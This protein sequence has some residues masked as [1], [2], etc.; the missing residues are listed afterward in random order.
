MMPQYGGI[1]RRRYFRLAYPVADRPVCQIRDRQ[2][3][4]VEI[5]EE[6]MRLVVAQARGF[7]A[8]QELAL[9]LQLH[10]GRNIHVVGEV[11]RMHDDQLVLKLNCA[12]PL[13]V[14]VA[15]QRYLLV[16]YPRHASE[17]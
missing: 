3:P 6:G 4:L 14:I 8:N 7:K 17:E 1:E 12:I 16:K 13:S 10:E 11:H 5:S 2:Y 9:T 15:E